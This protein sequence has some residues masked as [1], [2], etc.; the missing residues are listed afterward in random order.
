MNIRGLDCFLVDKRD[1][2]ASSLTL[3]GEDAKHAARVL[4]VRPGDRIAATDG[5]GM[6]YECAVERIEQNAVLCGVNDTAARL[7]E[8]DV[9]VIVGLS[10]LKN[11]SRFETAVE[12]CVEVGAAELVPLKCERTIA[13]HFRRERFEHI[14][15]AATKQSCR[16]VKMRVGEPES[17][18]QILERRADARIVLHE[19]TDTVSLSIPRQ[20]DGII[21]ILVGP[22]GGF[23]DGE[24]SEAIQKG[25]Q[26]AS[27]GSRRL[28]AETAAI[29]AV[30]AA[31]G[32]GASIFS[33]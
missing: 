31:C 17:F 25:W 14:V 7:N 3:R 28:R 15:L 27:L 18:R 2:T 32:T 6:M 4:R 21:I 8:P 1:V 9:R 12:K 16:S 33:A 19:K 5:E 30:A 11:P 10:L 23:T 29:A 22:E 20:K 26:T 13:H 24:I